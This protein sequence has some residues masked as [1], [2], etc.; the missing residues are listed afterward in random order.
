MRVCHSW[1]GTSKH[2]FFSESDS[3]RVC[4][5]S[6][7][8]LEVNIIH[9]SMIFVAQ[10]VTVSEW[11]C[12]LSDKPIPL[13]SS[14]CQCLPPA[15]LAEVYSGLTLSFIIVP[16][17]P[18]WFHVAFLIL[19]WGQKPHLFNTMFMNH[20]GRGLPEAVF[21]RDLSLQQLEHVCACI[22]QTDCHVIVSVI[23]MNLW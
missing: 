11:V 22:F 18:T 13:N 8:R 17:T 12:L 9:T 4:L 20:P 3:H 6:Y 16:P 1:D 7:N 5:S 2:V 19:H 10:T 14:T 23:I 21:A 15:L